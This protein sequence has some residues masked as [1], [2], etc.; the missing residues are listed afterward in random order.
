MGVWG[1]RYEEE[2]IDQSKFTKAEQ[3]LKHK[4]GLFK[5]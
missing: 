4:V 1:G 3:G 2:Q 5:E